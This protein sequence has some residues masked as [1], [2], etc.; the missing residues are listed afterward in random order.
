MK[1]L[2]EKTA[3]IIT[4]CAEKNLHTKNG[5]ATVFGLC[6]VPLYL[7]CKALDRL[8]IDVLPSRE[9]ALRFRDALESINPGVKSFLRD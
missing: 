7:L 5:I 1:E 4:D 2:R 6:H 9:S 8:N 3:I